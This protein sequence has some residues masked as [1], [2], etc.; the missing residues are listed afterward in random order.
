V[1]PRS[2]TSGLRQVPHVNR[3]PLSRAYGDAQESTAGAGTYGLW[4][5]PGAT[6]AAS[7]KFRPSRLR[8]ESGHMVQD[9]E[10]PLQ[11]LW[12]G[13]PHLVG[14]VVAR[15]FAAV[16]G[17]KSRGDCSGLNRLLD[18]WVER[19]P[20]V[21]GTKTGIPAGWR[22]DRLAQTSARFSDPHRL[23]RRASGSM[24]GRFLMRPEPVEGPSTGSGRNVPSS[25]RMES[26]LWR[27]HS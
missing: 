9:R 4:I 18:Q 7:Q 2:M 6:S 14:R 16:C 10:R 17:R 27:D 24:P 3:V 26:L 15:R 20:A 25:R 13:P 11:V 21:G 8:R 23:D 5:A 12:Q 19:S 22:F 1:P